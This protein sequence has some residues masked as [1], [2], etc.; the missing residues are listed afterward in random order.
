MIKGYEIEK[1]FLVEFPD[2]KKLKLKEKRSIF[3]TYLKNDENGTQKRVRKI[4]C[5]DNIIYTY[6]EKL[7][8]TSVTRK[9]ME[10]DIDESEYQR[11]LTQA[12]E[13]YPPVRKV[14]YVFEYEN[15]VFELDTYPFSADLA[16][17]EIEIENAEQQINFPEY[18]NIIKEVTDDVR[19]SNLSL[20]TA[21]EFPES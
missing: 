16:V 9:E 11:L 12:Q 6:T 7:F 1:R 19:Y 18:L 17:L 5:G 20:A 21:G 4:E 3:Q 8:L 15:Q 2:I 10:Y 14:R 13:D